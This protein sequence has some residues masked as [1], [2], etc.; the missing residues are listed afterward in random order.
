MLDDA[1]VNT[2]SLNP[3]EIKIYSS[4]GGT[5]P[6]AISQSYADDLIELPLYV[7][8]EEDG[9][10]NDN[11]A[12]YFYAEG[13]D[14]WKYEN[15]SKLYVFDKNIYA[16]KNYV[17]LKISSGNGKRITTASIAD[18]QVTFE[19]GSQT[20]YD[21]LPRIRPICWVQMQPP[22]VPENCGLANTW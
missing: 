1:G 5:L 21:I 9:K 19:T 13:A 15:S 11:D 22:L 20:V 12:I 14:H 16:Q 6:E 18:N 8:G 2:S 10:M 3:K 7:T 4:N 17:Y